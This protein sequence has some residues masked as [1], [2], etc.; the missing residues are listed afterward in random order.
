MKVGTI[1]VRKYLEQQAARLSAEREYQSWYEKVSRYIKSS[2]PSPEF[3]TL[4]EHMEESDR[5]DV[6]A[7]MIEAV[8]DGIWTPRF[9]SEGKIVFIKPKKADG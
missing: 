6:Y 7:R 8:V 4:L 5:P 9:N 2:D 1:T 3:L